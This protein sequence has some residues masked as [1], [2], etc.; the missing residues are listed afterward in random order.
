VNLVFDTSV[1]VDD[2]RHGT[3]RFLLPRIRGRCFLWFDSVAAA[4]LLAGCR[5]RAERRLVSRLL[6][7]FERAGRVLSPSHRDYRRAADAVSRLRVSGQT[8]RNPGA[9]MPDALQA[10]DALRIGALLVTRNDSDF[11]KLARHLPVSVQ[12]FDEFRRSVSRDST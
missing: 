11:R 6:S 7:P 8:L 3:L 2:L 10:A 12:S 5:T 4:E 9:A 1:W